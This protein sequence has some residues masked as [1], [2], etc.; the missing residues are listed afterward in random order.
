ML[1]TLFKL[2][3]YYNSQMPKFIALSVSSLLQFNMF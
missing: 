1:Y 3:Q 2:V